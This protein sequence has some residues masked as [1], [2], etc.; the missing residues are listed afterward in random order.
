MRPIAI[1]WTPVD[2]G[3]NLSTANAQIRSEI[4]VSCKLEKRNHPKNVNDPMIV[5]DGDA[6]VTATQRPPWK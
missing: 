6:F 2:G 4:L 5:L 1:L 3:S